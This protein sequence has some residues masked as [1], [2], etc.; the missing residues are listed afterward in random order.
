MDAGRDESTVARPYFGWYTRAYGGISPRKRPSGACM[1]L[2]DAFVH[3]RARATKSAGR[4]DEK[5]TGQTYLSVLNDIG[6][7]VLA[8]R[9]RTSFMRDVRVSEATGSGS[10]V[11]QGQAGA[12]DGRGAHQRGREARASSR[13]RAKEAKRRAERARASE[14]RAIE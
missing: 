6:G 13:E 12:G 8:S 5:R 11:G 10:E 7:T 2:P 4:V 1:D 14:K 9:A 3:S